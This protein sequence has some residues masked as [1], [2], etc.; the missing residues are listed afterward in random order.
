[1]RRKVKH[2]LGYDT[3][4]YS[5][6]SLLFELLHEPNITLFLSL[7]FPLCYLVY[8]VSRKID[9]YYTFDS[10]I[11]FILAENF[12]LF[13]KFFLIYQYTS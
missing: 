2:Y 6:D 11:V 9:E 3:K 1:M 5:I 8:L 7:K 10:L 4:N 13:I 12:V